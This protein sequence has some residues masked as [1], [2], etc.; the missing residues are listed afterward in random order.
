MKLRITSNSLLFAYV[1]AFFIYLEGPLV[2]IV[3]AS[4]NSGQIVRIPPDGL[5]LKWYAALLDLLRDAPGMKPGLVDT[6]FTSLWLGLASTVGAVIAGTLG[7]YALQRSKLP[8]TQI[9]RQL[10]MLPLLFPQIVTGI[11]LVLWFSAIGGVP[12][13]LRL[14]LGHLIITLPC[15]VITVTAS[16]ETLDRNLEDA[17]M[18]LGA[19]RVATFF[20]ITL[21]SIR[22]GVMAG[23]VF[24]WLTSFS[25]FTVTF[26]LF[27]GE[28]NP[29]PLWLYQYIQYYIDPGAAALATCILANTLCVLL[30]INRLQ[31]LGRV[32]AVSK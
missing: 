30:I 9:L 3:F 29:L 23:A 15:V 31:A 12:T 16:L 11:G 13:W 14:L 17:A 21:P 7:A 8:G 1:A 25:N 32:V 5:S 22:G 28:M 18:N 6:V 2:V 24:A 26:F 20:Y 19:N 10:F 27:S 4:F